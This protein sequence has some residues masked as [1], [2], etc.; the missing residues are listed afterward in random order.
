MRFARPWLLNSTT[1]FFSLWL[2]GNCLAQPGEPGTLAVP[3][4]APTPKLTVLGQ[5]ERRL[6]VSQERLG[7][8]RELAAR[9]ATSELAARRPPE[10]A[11]CYAVL[12]GLAG[13]YSQL[14]EQLG[15]HH[16][17]TLEPWKVLVEDIAFLEG[18]CPQVYQRVAE[19][20]AEGGMPVFAVPVP[21]T[22]GA[23]GAVSAAAPVATTPTPPPAAEA[24]AAPLAE[25]E[26]V[27]AWNKAAGLFDAGK[28]EEAIPGLASLLKTSYGPVAKE[29]LLKA[30]NE[31]AT[32]LRKQAA[33]IFVKARKTEGV[34]QKTKL[35]EE[36][37]ALLNKIIT[38][39]PEAGIVDKVRQNLAQIEE[40][41]ADLDPGL[42]QR[43]KNPSDE[44]D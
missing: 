22:T 12:E 1:V 18:E 39:Y 26:Q 33:G 38:T 5:M 27:E 34:S 42:L 4:G 6:L 30:Q 25:Q 36:S 20:A 13:G 23:P 8:W 37:W 3:Q 17:G 29:K 43:L 2:V 19:H 28:Y 9:T 35:L 24:Q 15:H 31:V 10:W 32:Q 7:R 40:Q 44:R 21:A 14:L 16:E 11:G 41:L